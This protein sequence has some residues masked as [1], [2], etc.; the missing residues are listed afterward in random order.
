MA[1]IDLEGYNQ[2]Y[3]APITIRKPIKKEIKI[4]IEALKN[5]SENKVIL[6]PTLLN[7][8][9]RDT[10]SSLGAKKKTFILGFKKYVEKYK[11]YKEDDDY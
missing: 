6:L 9:K 4:D 2:R 8:F 1:I 11:P 7:N 5:N 10:N 3:D